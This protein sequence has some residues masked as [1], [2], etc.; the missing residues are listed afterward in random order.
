[1][2]NSGPGLEGT[3]VTSDLPPAGSAA[4]VDLAGKAAV[5]E[6]RG[7]VRADAYWSYAETATLALANLASDSTRHYQPEGS[8]TIAVGTNEGHLAFRSAGIAV[9]D[10][11][12]YHLIEE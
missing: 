12:A 1:M 9:T 2:K 8:F 3:I 11:L 6:V 5:T 10:G 4:D 7:I